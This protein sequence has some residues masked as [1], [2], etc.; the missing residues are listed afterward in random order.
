M[1]RLWRFGS[2][3]AL[4]WAVGCGSERRDPV[5]PAEGPKVV[6]AMVDGAAFASQTVLG[7][8][9]ANTLDVSAYAS[10]QKLLIGSSVIDGPGT[11]PI[12]TN[13]TTAAVGFG[14]GFDYWAGEGSG[15]LT[16]TEVTPTRFSATF[17]FVGHFYSWDNPPPPPD[18]VRV[19]NGFIDINLP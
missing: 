11:Y 7:T 6:T 9:T 16:V 19:E 2:M 15:T 4:L 13:G 10:G 17:S 3:M 1:D 18:S 14:A 5:A 8:F 12:S